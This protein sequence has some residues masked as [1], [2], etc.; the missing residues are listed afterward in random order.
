MENSTPQSIATSRRPLQLRAKKVVIENVT[1]SV[2]RA[3]EP[4]QDK[5]RDTCDSKNSC[6][7]S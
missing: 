6:C 2:L 1:E 4:Q 5:W 7:A 3:Q